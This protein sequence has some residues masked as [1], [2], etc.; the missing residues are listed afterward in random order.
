MASKEQKV[1][2]LI[3]NSVEDHYFNPSIV[4]RYLADQPYYTVDRVMEMIVHIISQQ[5]SRHDT[6]VVDNLTSEGILLA[7]ELNAAVEAIK[8][9]NEFKN[10]KLPRSHKQ[11]MAGVKVEQPKEYKLGWVHDRYDNATSINVQAVIM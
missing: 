6:E 9:L 11:I 4:A 2:E 8:E 5:S 1:A 3:A 10:L 7:R